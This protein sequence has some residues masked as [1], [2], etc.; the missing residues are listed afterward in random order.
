MSFK[1]KI[2]K[3]QNKLLENLGRR[4]HSSP[5]PKIFSRVGVIMMILILMSTDSVYTMLDIVILLVGALALIWFIL[6]GY[7]YLL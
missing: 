3:I 1:I 7:R 6:F 4:L 2:Q 5:F